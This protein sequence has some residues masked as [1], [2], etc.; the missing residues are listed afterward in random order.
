MRFVANLIMMN[1]SDGDDHTS[2]KLIMS[3]FIC[4]VTVCATADQPLEHFYPC[5]YFT[6]THSQIMQGILLTLQTRQLK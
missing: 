4:H 3:C 6:F 2:A 1:K 5:F